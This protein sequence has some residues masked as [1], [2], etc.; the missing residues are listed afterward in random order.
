MKK[1][2]LRFRLLPVIAFMAVY[3][4][5]VLISFTLS[6]YKSI[7]WYGGVNRFEGTSC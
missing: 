4:A 2:R 7:A 1:Y 5:S 6:E 3:T